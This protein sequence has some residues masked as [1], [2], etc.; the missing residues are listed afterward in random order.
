MNMKFFE[1][2][3]GIKDEK[4]LKESGIIEEAFKEFNN[5]TIWNTAEATAVIEHFFERDL[6]LYRDTILEFKKEG[7]KAIITIYF[8]P[9]QHWSDIVESNDRQNLI[10]SFSDTDEA[11]KVLTENSEEA[12][13]AFI[14]MINDFYNEQLEP[15]KYFYE[16]VEEVR[17][18]YNGLAEVIAKD[19][20]DAIF[21]DYINS[22]DIEIWRNNNL[23]DEDTE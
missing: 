22:N 14:E 15:H 1:K 23:I 2:L 8:E 6:K 20:P 19:D 13:E 12:I 10:E 3:Y 18:V 11:E 5:G 7:E 9:D 21:V 4:S 17:Q 16:A